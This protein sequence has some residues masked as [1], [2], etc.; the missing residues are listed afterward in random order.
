MTFLEEELEHSIQT[1][2]GRLFNSLNNGE[3]FK[4]CDE[5]FEKFSNEL[6]KNY[7]NKELVNGYLDKHKIYIFRKT[8]GLHIGYFNE[9]LEAN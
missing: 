5:N 6:L 1:L 9:I 2:V 4:I 7:Q 8:W 3:I